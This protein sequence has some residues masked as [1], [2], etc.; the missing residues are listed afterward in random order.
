MKSRAEVLKTFIFEDDIQTIHIFNEYKSL[1]LNTKK[2]SDRDKISYKAKRHFLNWIRKDPKLFKI[3]DI[4]SY[5][6][7]DSQSGRVKYAGMQSY[8]K[9]QS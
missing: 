1:K 4:N 8:S 6:I 5:Q 2:K 7:P 9:I 3:Q